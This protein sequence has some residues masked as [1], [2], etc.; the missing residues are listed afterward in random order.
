MSITI[1]PIEQLGAEALT[2]LALHANSPSA[3]TVAARAQNA[4]KLAAVVAA[5]GA[6]NADGAMTALEAV[7]TSSD[8]G[9]QQ[10]ISD[11]Y[12]QAQSFL[13]F[14]LQLN[15]ATP[16]IGAAAQAIATNVAAGITSVATAYIP[17]AA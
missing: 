17:K 12:S 2:L 9:V 11:F 3:T 7:T 4:L 10:F 5:V 1:K 14:Q 8:P 6:G 16:L 15:A 13:Q